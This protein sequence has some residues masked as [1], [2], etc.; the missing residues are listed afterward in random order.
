MYIDISLDEIEYIVIEEMLNDILHKYI[1]EMKDVDHV[2][3]E[4]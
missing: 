2:V 3:I 4:N 1:Y